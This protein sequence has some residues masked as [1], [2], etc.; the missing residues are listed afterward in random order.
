MLVVVV[1][2]SPQHSK[3]CWS[4]GMTFSSPTFKANKP[5]QAKITLAPNLYQ[6]TKIPLDL[7]T[8]HKFGSSCSKQLCLFTSILSSEDE[9]ILSY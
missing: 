1:A 5:T 9:W 8:W 4:I 7:L 6:L 3:Q 2:T